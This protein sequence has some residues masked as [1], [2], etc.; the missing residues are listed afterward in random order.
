LR[1]GSR[2][3][4]GYVRVDRSG[5]RAASKYC[6]NEKPDK[7]LESRVAYGSPDQRSEEPLRLCRSLGD[8]RKEA[9]VL[10]NFALLS[11]LRGKYNQAAALS[12][13]S[14]AL[15]RELLDHVGVT[16]C[17]DTLAARSAA[18]GDVVRAVRLWGAAEALREANNVR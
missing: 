1:G 9:V 4:T 11:L 12:S 10:N 14:L 17:P 18:Q 2:T 13:E 8:R 15:S 16:A 6:W 5:T 7:R 3:G